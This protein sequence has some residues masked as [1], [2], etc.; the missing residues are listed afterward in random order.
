MCGQARNKDVKKWE[1][2]KTKKYKD[3]CS[4]SI[5]AFYVISLKETM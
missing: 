1:N 2:K 4:R 5:V 3:R